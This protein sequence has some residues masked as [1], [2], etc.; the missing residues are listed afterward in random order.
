ML[1]FRIIKQLEADFSKVKKN[2]N[3]AFGMIL[4]PT[5]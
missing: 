1:K 2:Y 4:I 5:N 3:W